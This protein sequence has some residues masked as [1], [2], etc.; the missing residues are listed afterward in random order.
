MF[1]VCPIYEVCST[2]VGGLKMRNP[3]PFLSTGLS[4]DCMSACD[5]FAKPLP[6][7]QDPAK[8]S[9]P[10]RP[11]AL[12]R[13]WGAGG[14]TKYNRCTLVKYVSDRHELS[15]RTAAVK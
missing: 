6:V 4:A 1:G 15:N 7:K 11:G 14:G 9:K 5:V 12:E 2:A 8:T 10:A 13:E 3:P